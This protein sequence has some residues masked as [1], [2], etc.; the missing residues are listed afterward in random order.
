MDL[1]KLI[2]VA[3]QIDQVCQQQE[4]HVKHL[5]QLAARARKENRS[6]THEIVEQPNVF[7]MSDLIR[8]LRKALRAKPKKAK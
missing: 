6:L 1:E 4:N 8:D 5:Q 3:Q 7:D 2:Q